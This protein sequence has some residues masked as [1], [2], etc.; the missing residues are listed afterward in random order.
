MKALVYGGPW[1]MTVEDAP[2]PQPGAGEL[3]VEPV[4]VG[5]CGSDVHG[6]IGKT[7][8]RK[9]PMIMGH[10]FAGRV[11]GVGSGVS[12]F[13]IGDAVVVS[14][15]QACGVCINCRVGLTNICTQR[16]VLGVDI[17]GAYAERL[18]I[19]EEMAFPKPENLS[20]R[21]AAMSEPLAV[22]L[23]AVEI[24]P[25]RLM[26]TVA[27]VGAGTIGLL[28][29]M[30]ARLKGA[31]RIIVTDMMPHR[32]DLARQ[33]GA[34][35]AINVKEQDPIQAVKDLTGGL[36]GTGDDVHV[37]EG[38][39]AADLVEAVRHGDDNT[40]VEP[41][42]EL[43]RL[44]EK[45]VEQ[46][47]LVGAGV[48]EHILDARGLHLLDQQL[49]AGSG[50]LAAG[51]GGAGANGLGRPDGRRDAGSAHT[52]GRE[53]LDET[54]AGKASAN[55]AVDE[56]SHVLSPCAGANRLSGIDGVGRV[57]PG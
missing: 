32:L 33:L 40:F 52:E 51:A 31:G 30:A 16:H 27:I 50:D 8:R 49:A 55:K 11:T 28:T 56:V 54:A 12:R 13:E 7:G 10:E 35:V 4:A 22:A 38:G 39:L 14:P 3:L 29:L 53:G 25:I 9:P 15:I 5:I 6:F 24:T 21:R 18:V 36:G 43:H 17:A 20:W 44:I 45:C 48:G 23:H 41:H 34:D 57:V 26:Q 19:K 1:T 42:D 37:R 2:D 47:N 46:A